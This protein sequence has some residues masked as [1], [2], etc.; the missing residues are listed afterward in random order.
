MAR[1]PRRNEYLA[2]IAADN[3]QIAK[4][5]VFRPTSATPKYLI[6]P[7]SVKFELDEKSVKIYNLCGI[8]PSIQPLTSNVILCKGTSDAA[9]IQYENS[10]TLNFANGVTPGGGYIHGAIAQEEELCRQYPQLYA[11]LLSISQNKRLNPYPNL[12][13]EIQSGILYTPNAYRFRNVDYSLV[14]RPYQYTSFISAAAPDMSRT[15]DAIINVQIA[16]KINEILDLIFII[17]KQYNIDTLIIGAWG[18]GAFAPRNT[19]TTYIKQIAYLICNKIKCYKKLYQNVV[20][21]IPGGENYNIFE[22]MLHE[23]ALI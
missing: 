15:P 19:K 14:A 6:I 1:D 23:F 2:T 21:A 16:E 4:Q 18:C 17:P 3:R 20:V 10:A 8:S 9:I 5:F 7:Q 12:S 22:N 13:F 11:S